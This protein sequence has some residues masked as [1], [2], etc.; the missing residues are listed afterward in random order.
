MEIKN[1]YS[2]NY[3]YQEMLIRQLKNI[4][5]DQMCFINTPDFSEKLP[6]KS[7]IPIVQYLDY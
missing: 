2:E 5:D 1:D 4:M 3:P 6:N 7:T